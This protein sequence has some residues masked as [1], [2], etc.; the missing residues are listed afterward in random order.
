MRHM[1]ALSVVGVLLLGS[2]VR[3]HPGH[4]HGPDLRVWRDADGLFEIG[5]ALLASELA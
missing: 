3:A 4:D 5:Q 1:L 2:T